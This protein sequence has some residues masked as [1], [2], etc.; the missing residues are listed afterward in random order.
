MSSR[1]LEFI[2]MVSLLI[3]CSSTPGDNDGFVWKHRLGNSNGADPAAVTLA[4]QKDGTSAVVIN[5]GDQPDL[6]RESPHEHQPMSRAVKLDAAGVELWHADFQF[7]GVIAQPYDITMDAEGNVTVLGIN[8]S[9]IGR[10]DAN[11][12]ASSPNKT[13][14]GIDQPQRIVAVE[15][16]KIVVVG[17]VN[18]ATAPESYVVELDADDQLVWSRK[19]AAGTPEFRMSAALGPEGEIIVGGV[20]DVGDYHYDVWF[21][22]YD[23]DGTELWHEPI[24]YATD[25]DDDLSD[26]AVFPDGK[27][28]AVGASCSLGQCTAWANLYD[29]SGAEVWPRPLQ[30]TTTEYQDPFGQD[31]TAL[32][33]STGFVGADSVAVDPKGSAVVLGRRGEELWAQLIGSDGTLVQACADDASCKTQLIYRRTDEPNRR[34][35][36]IDPSGHIQMAWE[37]DPDDEED[38]QYPNGNLWVGKLAAPLVP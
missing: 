23:T 9:W 2:V 11:G 17:D 34:A 5:V 6:W 33:E 37:T 29:G 16:G 24:K 30:L 4:M 25:S 32:D 22:K 13:I 12:H 20:V 19:F 31:S 28:L 35:A 26:L 15:N 8:P 27:L 1:A 38:G 14:P 21:Q 7:P 18:V 10:V 3:G 36:K